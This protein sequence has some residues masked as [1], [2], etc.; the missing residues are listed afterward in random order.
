MV[1][2]IKDDLRLLIIVGETG[3]VFALF[4]GNTLIGAVRQVLNPLGM[5]QVRLAGLVAEELSATL[6]VHGVEIRLLRALVVVI[7]GTV[8]EGGEINSP[9]WPEQPASQLLGYLSSFY[10]EKRVLLLGTEEVVPNAS[11]QQMS[12]PMSLQAGISFA[13]L[14]LL[15]LRR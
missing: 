13:A 6:R 2:P 12:D 15:D 1:E 9:L 8:T 3:S 7:P 4:D 10:T 14:G 11:K 5:S